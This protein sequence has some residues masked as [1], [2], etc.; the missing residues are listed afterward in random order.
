MKNL[1]P[2]YISLPLK[3]VLVFMGITK[4]KKKVKLSDIKFKAEENIEWSDEQLLIKKDILNGN[5]VDGYSG[6][7]PMISIDNVCLDGH[8]RL[9][10]L[11]EYSPKQVVIVEKSLIKWNFLKKM[12]EKESI[13]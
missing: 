2:K 1:D 12:L 11:K 9:L 3:I 6:D 4:Y 5:Y 13:I 8:H 10:T 7:Y